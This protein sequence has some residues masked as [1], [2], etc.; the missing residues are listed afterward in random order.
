MYYIFNLVGDRLNKNCTLWYLHKIKELKRYSREENITVISIWTVPSSS[1]T[2]QNH[3][4]RH[5]SIYHDWT[6]KYAIISIDDFLLEMN[7]IILIPFFLV[8]NKHHNKSQ[9]SRRKNMQTK[10]L[11][12]THTCM[13]LWMEKRFV[14]YLLDKKFFRSFYTLNYRI[15]FFRSFFS[16]K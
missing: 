12:D 9:M 5:S 13:T 3:I 14:R 11:V 15:D 10:C 8:E 2:T 7:A 16:L 1:M 4:D 6:H